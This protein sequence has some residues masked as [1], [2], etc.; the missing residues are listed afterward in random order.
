MDFVSD[1]LFGVGHVAAVLVVIVVIIG[2]GRFTADRLGQPKVVGEITVGLLAGPIALWLLGPRRFAAVLPGELFAGLQFLTHAALA[3]FLVGTIH[4]LRLHP[5]RGSARA[6]GWTVAGSLVPAA[7]GVL[8]AG[9]VLFAGTPSVRGPASAASLM[10]MLAL[11]LSV[12]AVPVLARILADRRMTETQS[13]RVA[14]GA[15]V[16]ID[17]ACWLLLPVA[18]GLAGGQLAEFVRSLVVLAG[19]ALTAL[20]VRG[21]LRRRVV[22]RWCAGRP[23]WTRALIGALAVGMA[24]A[25]EELGLTVIFGAVLAGMAVPAGE[26]EHWKNAVEKVST[27]GRALV[28][29]FFVVTGITVFTKDFGAVPV[30]LIVLA[31]VLGAGG[32]LVGS[33]LGARLGGQTRWDSM[34]IGAM[35]NTRGL[36]ELIVLQFGYSTGILTASVF[37]ALVVM[38]LVTTALTGPLLGLIDRAELRRRSRVEVVDGGYRRVN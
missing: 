12:T 5:A 17:S 28:P 20:A 32:K 23:G 9:Y 13:G 38:A 30:L 15:A 1:L 14:F 4:K 18:A 31:V 7:T 11:S 16:V 24:L 37:L 36:T 34:R 25:V 10:V 27:L 6:I 21:L 2:L 33:Y 3:L 29:I 26:G 35:L 19:S 22:D 8:L